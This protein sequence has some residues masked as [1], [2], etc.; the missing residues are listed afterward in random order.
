MSELRD[1]IAAA[2][3]RADGGDEQPDRYEKLAD[4]VIRE[5]GLARDEKLA[6]AVIRELGLARPKQAWI[7]AGFP[8]RY[9]YVTDWKADDE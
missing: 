2:L 7:D 1:R 5:L 8:I 9:R 6:D 4:A 3:Q